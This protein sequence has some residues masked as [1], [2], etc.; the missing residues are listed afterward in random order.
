MGYRTRL[1]LE[2]LIFEILGSGECIWGLVGSRSG[3]YLI[4]EH[5][6]EKSRFVLLFNV[7]LLGNKV[8]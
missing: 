7:T 1:R 4:I 6:E 2:G 3:H 8:C 5:P